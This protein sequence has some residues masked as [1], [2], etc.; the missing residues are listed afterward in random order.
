[1][2]ELQEKITYLED[3]VRVWSQTANNLHERYNDLFL[4]H[5]RLKTQLTIA[6]KALHKITDAHDFTDAY[7]IAKN[8]LR[9]SM[10]DIDDGK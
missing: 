4:E 9:D 8:A 6:Q 7:L 3:R 5:I 1:M 2:S 10:K